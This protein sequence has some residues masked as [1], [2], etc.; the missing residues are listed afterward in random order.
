MP[1]LLYSFEAFKATKGD[2]KKNDTPLCLDCK[3]VF[4]LPRMN[5]NLLIE[6]LLHLPHH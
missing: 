2:V 3:S 1:I 5:D 4:T 6:H